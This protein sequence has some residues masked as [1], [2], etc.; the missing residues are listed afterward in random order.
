MIKND[1]KGQTELTISQF[2]FLLPAHTFTAENFASG[3]RFKE[4]Y[5]MKHKQ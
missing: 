2:I 5:H 1:K 3:K 4:I